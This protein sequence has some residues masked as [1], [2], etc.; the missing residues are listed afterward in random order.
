MNSISPMLSQITISGSDLA[1]NLLVLFVVVLI[2]LIIWWLGKYFFPKL[3][4][5]EIGMMVW[6]GLFVLIAAFCVINFLATMV[7][8]PLVRLH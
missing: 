3:G 1:S 6:N 8:H 7:G 4:M 2:G 5:P